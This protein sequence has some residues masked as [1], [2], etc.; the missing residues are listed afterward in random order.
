M[1]SKL[2][3][4]FI[5]LLISSI[6]LEIKAQVNPEAIGYY[7]DALR[8]SRTEFAGTAR[9]QG[10]AGAQT[11]LG[12]DL[13]SIVGNPA[14]LGFFRRSE[15]N[16]NLGLGF[17]ANETNYLS[18]NT[19]STKGN[20]NLNGFGMSFYFGK[21][22][23]EGG[24]WRGGSF[25]VSLNRI[26]DFQDRFK[27]AGSNTNTSITDAFVDRVN[28]IDLIN[29]EEDLALEFE[30]MTYF[31][32]LVN[33]LPD[34]SGNVFDDTR[35]Y[36]TYARDENENLLG[37][38]RQEESV[39]TKGSQ[40]QWSFSY[41]GNY[42]HKL[43][44]GATLGVTTLNYVRE[45]SFYERIEG[46]L[47]FLDDLSFEDELKIRGTGVN[48]SLGLI[49]RPIDIVRFGVSLTTPTYY[50]LREEF[51]SNVTANFFDLPLDGNEVLTQAQ[52]ETL[53][54]DFNFRL[55][56]PLRA[57]AGMAVFLGKYGFISADAEYIDFQNMQ[58]RNSEFTNLLNA[59]NETINNLYRPVWHYRV[60]AEGRLSVLRLRGGVAYYQDPY[61]TIDGIDRSRLYYTGGVGI[62]L[63]EGYID[64]ALVYHQ[65]NAVF[66]PY[67]FASDSP[68]AG[69]EPVAE[70]DNQRTRIVISG[71]IYF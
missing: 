37:N 68:Y 58:V 71:G 1:P 53:P 10:L 38:A 65:R 2:P 9:Y 32:Y 69:L 62:R 27:Y 54:G 7:Q 60:G 36:F 31:A 30:R 16:F 24:K 52:A 49:Y 51:S 63:P 61:N 12:G 22:D 14:G 17:I 43:Y 41:A 67:S 44:F 56:T 4:V 45:R 26:N 18:E 11:A 66:L 46:E 34:N 5:S 6:I 50:A 47:S 15:F 64:L 42:D 29:V 8:F 40:Y 48:L 59:D 39:N 13:G 21:D 55:I 20:V 19:N 25:A 23:V 57:S 3:L 28:G 70:I 35:E 33:P